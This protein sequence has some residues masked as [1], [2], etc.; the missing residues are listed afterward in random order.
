MTLLLFRQ[1][2]HIYP[3]APTFSGPTRFE[4]ARG[5][6]PAVTGCIHRGSRG[7]QG[8]A[9]AHARVHM[10]THTHVNDGVPAVAGCIHQGQ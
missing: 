4:D 8:D 7:D 6:F 9:H 3:E 2:P 1:V 5:P 10:R